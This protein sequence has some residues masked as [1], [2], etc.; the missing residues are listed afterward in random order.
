M[1]AWQ[2]AAGLFPGLKYLR[3]STAGQSE[4][5]YP[6]WT[7]AC[8]ALCILFFKYLVAKIFITIAGAYYLFLYFFFQ[9]FSQLLFEHM[10]QSPCPVT[11]HQ[12]FK[13]NNALQPSPSHQQT[14]H[15]GH[16]ILTEKEKM[17]GKWRRTFSPAA[18]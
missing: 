3:S 6:E 9:E 7:E 2:R 17:T 15:H 18:P 5:C 8:G 4:D 1:A 11:L 14:S 12:V 10:T 13:I 16:N